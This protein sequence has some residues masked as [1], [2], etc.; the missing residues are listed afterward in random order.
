MISGRVS[1]YMCLPVYTSLQ[2]SYM[3]GCDSVCWLGYKARSDAWAY[4]AAVFP[5]GP[6][7]VQNGL[8]SFSL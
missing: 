6:A 4:T 1:I 5:S 3:H 2:P 8:V 7:L